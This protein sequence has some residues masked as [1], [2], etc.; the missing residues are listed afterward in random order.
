MRYRARFLA[1]LVN[2]VV[3]IAPLCGGFFL[4]VLGYGLF[5]GMPI[6]PRDW[7]LLIGVFGGTLVFTS[8]AMS[9]SELFDWYEV[10]ATGLSYRAQA[11]VGGARRQRA[12]QAESGS[13]TPPCL[14]EPPGLRKTRRPPESMSLRGGPAG[15]AGVVPRG[16]T[17]VTG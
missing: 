6:E 9:V 11:G 8:L 2:A 3:K 10:D 7:N 14:E 4:L 16:A 17:P 5:K 15:I 13:T 12:P 1:A